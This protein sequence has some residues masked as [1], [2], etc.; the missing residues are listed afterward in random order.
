[1]GVNCRVS[2]CS[3][4]RRPSSPCT[5]D[6]EVKGREIDD[7]KAQNINRSISDC[8]RW[9]FQAFETSSIAQEKD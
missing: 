1:M 9:P 5:G 4:G 7:R 2:S 3:A 6:C 8:Q